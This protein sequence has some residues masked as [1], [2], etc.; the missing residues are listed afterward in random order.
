MNRLFALFFFLVSINSFGHF[1]IDEKYLN[2][3]CKNKE[4]INKRVLSHRYN[5]RISQIKNK[6]NALIKALQLNCKNNRSLSKRIAKIKSFTKKKKREILQ[7]VIGS[8]K[9]K[10]KKCDFMFTETIEPSSFQKIIQT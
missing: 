1:D 8:I 5:Y 4:E 7:K 10:R 2:A 6:E 3:N 9:S